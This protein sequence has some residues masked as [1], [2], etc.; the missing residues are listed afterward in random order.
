MRLHKMEETHC[1]VVKAFLL[2][3][4]VA[5]VIAAVLYMIQDSRWLAVKKA[6]LNPV[7]VNAVEFRSSVSVKK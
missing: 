3:F 2:G 5:S 1:P 4:V 6:V 7:A